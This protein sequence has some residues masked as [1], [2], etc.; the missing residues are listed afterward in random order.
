L[1][2]GGMAEGHDKPALR[3]LLVDDDADDRALAMRALRQAFPALEARQVA[4]REEL[5]QALADGGYDVAITDYQLGWSDGI[6]VLDA[7]I[8]RFPDLPVVMFTS[9]GNEE[10]CAEGMKRG[11]SDYVLKR[12]GQ[13]Q[14]LALAIRGAL[15]R[16]ELR[17]R[18]EVLLAKEREARQ[19]A[20]RASRLKEEFLATLSHELRTPLHAVLGWT[21]LLKQGMLKGPD[22][23]RAL[24]VIERNARA[25]ASLI[26]ELLDFSRLQSGKLRLAPE[27][28]EIGPVVMS[29]IAT[30]QP[31]AQARGIVLEPRIGEGTGRVTADPARLRQ[32]VLNLLTNAI[33]FSEEG[34]KVRV[35]VERLDGH[36]AIEVSDEGSGIPPDFLPYIF[37]PFRQADA[38]RTRRSGGMGIGLAL[39]RKLTEAHGGTVEA[40]SPG[41]DQGSTFTIRLPLTETDAPPKHVPIPDREKPPSL[42]GV[43]VLAVDDEADSLAYLEQLLAHCQAQ[44]HTASEAATAERL[45][46]QHRP[47]VIVCDIGMPGTDGYALVQKIRCLNDHQLARTPAIA[48]TAFARSEDRERALLAGF[49]NHIAKPVDGYE[50]IVVVA[51]LVGV[52]QRGE[53]CEVVNE[54]PP[55]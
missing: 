40:S 31:S 35:S 13:Y 32:M 26:E 37:D 18:V 39:V 38:S 46:L 41:V 55:P 9:S 51:A 52:L 42:E 21:G 6:Q 43:K 53:R 33:K 14:R 2:H 22:E 29:A 11:L 36:T 10:V 12:H 16:R 25:Q 19:E 17:G 48:L 49:D 5:D 27:E 20:E 24:D 47:H 44:V 4:V 7:L 23:R 3:V 45:L 15:D 50:L 1:L 54:S 8:E 34:G 28:V 30:V